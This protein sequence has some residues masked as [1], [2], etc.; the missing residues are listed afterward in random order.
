MDIASLAMVMSQ[1]QVRQEASMAVLKMVMNAPAQQMD[2]ITA[3]VSAMEKSV[4]PHL[5]SNIDVAG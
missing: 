5:G 4:N 3:D 2:D 1:T